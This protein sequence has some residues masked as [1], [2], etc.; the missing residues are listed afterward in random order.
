M[1]KGRYHFLDGLRG[2]AMLLGL[3]L[4]G[5]MSFRW[6]EIWGADEV[7]AAP[8]FFGWVFDAIH[9]FRMQL[10]FVVSGFFTMM[11]AKKR[12]LWALAKQRLLRIGVSLVVGT[13]VLTPMIM[14][15]MAWGESR[16]EER[17]EVVNDPEES[18]FEGG[19]LL[20]AVAVGDTAR[21][22]KLIETGVDL[23]EMGDTGETALI[24]AAFF[25]RAESVAMLIEA[26]ADVEAVDHHGTNPLKA[27]TMNFEIVEAIA[28]SFELEADEEGR[29][30]CAKMLREAGATGAADDHKMSG[31]IWMLTFY[32][33]FH[34]LWFLY[35][36]CWL[37][38][39]FFVVAK[40]LERIPNGLVTSPAALLWLIPLAW[41]FQTK[42]SGQVGPGTATG[43]VPHWPKLGY[44][45]VFFFF[46]AL[47]YG[48]GLLEDRLG[49]RWP[50]WLVLAVPCLIFAR[51]W[52]WGGM[53]V[54]AQL[55]A[56]CY[57][58]L[59]ITVFFGIFRQFLNQGHPAVRYLSDTSYWLYLAQLPLVMVVQ[60]LVG[61]WEMTVWVKFP[62]VLLAVTIPLLV[63]YE[64]VVRYTWIGAILNGRK[65]RMKPPALPQGLRD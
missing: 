2:V 55:A 15:V 48:R 32:P 33:V 29:K 26:G 53:E 24:S 64:Y 47:C 34:H 38:A 41:Y 11:L 42:M 28:D 49:K 35:Y 56:V 60:I 45:A 31:L 52:L 16:A 21:V 61:R 62:L 7:S 1:T 54:W 43:I 9:G 50:L 51:D 57:A 59:M 22:K 63:V 14:G 17:A 4:H 8:E 20:K 3:V 5:A 13:I 46:G 12:G 25:G 6:P 30:E 37:V 65:S 58:W 19:K 18:G 36:L 39:A 40:L 10:F 44:Y 27:A 23:E